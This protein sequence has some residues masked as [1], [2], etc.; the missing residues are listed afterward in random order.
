MR[1]NR[2]ADDTS[3]KKLEIKDNL[4]I[5]KICGSYLPTC[6][7]CRFKTTFV[8]QIM[9]ILIL[10]SGA[11]EYAIA[12]R[13]SFDK[14]V[15][16]IYFAPGNAASLD[17]GENISYKSLEELKEFALK[18]S[19]DLTIVGPE[20][21]LTQ[22]VVDVFRSANLRIFGPTKAAAR[23]EGSKA[24]MKDFL[25]KHKIPTA[26]YV[27]TSNKEEAFSFIDTLKEPIVVKADGLCAGKG[28]IIAATK[29][30]A[31]QAVTDML[32][33]K[34]FK[35]AGK[36]VVVEEFLKG[37]ELSVFAICDGKDYVVLPACQDHKRL[38]D[39][40]KGPNT[41]GM[42]AFC[43]APM[44]TPELMQKIEN[45]IIKPTLKGMKE[46]NN[47][48]VGVLFCGI[49][50]VDNEPFTLEFNVRFGDPECQVLMPL[51]NSGATEL[52]M[53]ACDGKL[54]QLNVS[55]KN[56]SSICVVLASKD[57]PYKTSPKEPIH[58]NFK[59]IKDTHICFGGVDEKGGMLYA[60]GGRV[61]SC[62]ATAKTLQD[63]ARNAYE[64]VR[65]VNF[66]GMQYRQDIANQ[67]L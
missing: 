13:L 4:A 21:P 26:A 31:K 46:D 67:A 42:G 2:I 58:I 63:A 5:C 6:Y 15:T 66:K 27:Q 7:N 52:F 45:K 1:L 62:V 20:E 17:F 64:L 37:F 59:N 25:K 57:Y 18:M 28:V 3:K 33:G 65:A 44:A 41:G 34:S 24:F 12:R 30:D 47:P 11:R 55:F 19:I 53:A 40:D 60:S 35:D 16:K 29:T 39:G 49:M 50:V 32:D 14:N 9:K 56:K 8:G 43:P 54:A 61:L 38:L 22:G 51:I 23:L 36:I 10:G 48:F